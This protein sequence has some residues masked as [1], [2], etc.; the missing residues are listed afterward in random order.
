MLLKD[1]VIVVTG[2]GPG[3]G[4]KL[5]LIGAAEGAKLALG[6]RSADYLAMVTEEVRDAGGEAVSI[7]T[8]IDNQEHCDQLAA[9]ALE[10]F[11]RIDGLVNNAYLHGPFASFEATSI[12]EWQAVMSVT[13]FGALRMV[14]AVLP[15]MKLNG[16]AILNVSSMGSVQPYPGGAGYATAKAAL[17]GATRQLAKELGAY[18]IRVNA[19]RMGRMDGVPWH[20]AVKYMSAASGQT[21]DEIEAPFRKLIALGELP[22]DEDCAK[23]ALFFVSDYSKVISGVSVDVNGGEYMAG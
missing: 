8:D 13:C 9:K 11:G 7:P 10:A 19:T 20:N 2:I 23:S 14:K 17:E 6:A 21:R 3:M 18:K 15:A 4:R 12:D 1:K 16:G 22:P 5:A